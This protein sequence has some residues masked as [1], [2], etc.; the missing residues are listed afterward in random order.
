VLVQRDTTS[1]NTKYAEM[2]GDNRDVPVSSPDTI[3]DPLLGLCR[4]FIDKASIINKAHEHL[5]ESKSS[6]TTSLCTE[7]PAE[8]DAIHLP[9]IQRSPQSDP[10]EF[11]QQLELLETLHSLYESKVLSKKMLSTYLFMTS[12][13]RLDL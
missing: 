5:K 8:I 2:G 3:D 10:S 11:L 12:D 9:V 4:N 6:K 7:D 13:Y 1:V